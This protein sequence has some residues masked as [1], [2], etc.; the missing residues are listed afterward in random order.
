MSQMLI[1][2]SK[3]AFRG[4]LAIQTIREHL[5]GFYELRVTCVDASE[6]VDRETGHTLCLGCDRITVI[7]GLRECDIC[8]KEY[9]DKT[10]YQNP[11]Y[12]TN[13]PDCVV[14]HGL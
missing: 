5:C 11:S 10:K 7:S 8:I 3:D 14:T 6:R 2:P 4:R 9:I 1:Y 12:E 13:C